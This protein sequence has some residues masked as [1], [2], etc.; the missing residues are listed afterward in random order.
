M[1][2]AQAQ[3]QAHGQA[4]GHTRAQARGEGGPRDGSAARV[5]VGIATKGRPD[6]LAA[7]LDNLAAQ[8]LKPHAIVVCCTEPRDAGAVAADPNVTVIYRE[9]GLPRQ[10][11]AILDAMPEGTDW[12]VF[13]DDDYYPDPRWLETVS[14]TFR[15]DPGIACITGYVVADGIIGP[16]L[17]REEALARV[18]AH[19][20]SGGDWMV[21]EASPYGCNMAF[22]RTAIEGL[23][24]DER[25]VL[26]GWLEDR[27]FGSA[28]ARRGYRRVKIG[29]AYGA[30]LGVKGGRVSGRKFGYSQVMN[31][32]YLHR[33]SAMTARQALR[34]ISRNVLAN[35]VRSARP[36]PYVDRRGRLLGNLIAALDLLRLRLTPE[37]A[38]SL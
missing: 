28:V 1:T 25:L 15:S 9:P 33:K 16:G 32:V 7:M 37:R 24:F 4:H 35:L 8:T 20:S 17:T 3:S 29:K 2:I 18:A 23:R 38:A 12:I 27:D 21:E 5:C 22:R 30:H 36:E 31:P 26:Y 6:Q 13:F 14:E 19:D 11:N 10:R 34:Q